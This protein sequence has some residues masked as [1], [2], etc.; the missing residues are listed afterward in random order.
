[1]FSFCSAIPDHLKQ[2]F[3]IPVRLEPAQDPAAQALVASVASRLAGDTIPTGQ[4]PEGDLF[5]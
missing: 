5:S 2:L 4:T 3:L 1:M